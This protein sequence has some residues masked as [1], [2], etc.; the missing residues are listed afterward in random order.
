MHKIPELGR[1]DDL[2]VYNDPINR[3]NA[4]NLYAKLLKNGAKAKTILQTIDTMTEE[5]CATILQSF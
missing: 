2:F 3:T 5:E 4:F 1:L